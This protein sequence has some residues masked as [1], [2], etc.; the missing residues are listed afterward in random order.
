MQVDFLKIISAIKQ[1]QKPQQLVMN[2]LEGEMS[3]T[4]MG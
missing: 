4:P 2:I 1:G 3:N